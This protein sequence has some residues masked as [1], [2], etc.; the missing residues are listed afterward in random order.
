MGGEHDFSGAVALVTGAARGQ[1]A[2][3][4][5]AF[6]AAGARVVVADVREEQ[7]GVLAAELGDSAVF[8]HLDVS[9]EDAWRRAIELTRATFGRLDVLVNNAGVFR[10]RALEREDPEEFVRVLSIN[11]V[12][13]FLGTRAVVGLMRDTGGGSIVN[14]GSIAGLQPARGT[15]A[16]ATS[17]WG[18]RGLT[19]VS[20]L[21]LARSSIRVNLVV[22]GPI[23]TDML[24]RPPEEVAAGVPLGRVGDPED[25]ARAVLYLASGQASFVTGSEL[26]VDGGRLLE[27]RQTG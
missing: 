27:G 17:K 22:P 16:Y 18:L 25:V 12:G 19:R 24:P 8:A 4:A 20:A 26:V 13:A 9:D 15:A 11:L 7:G 23:A 1:G 2:A 10:T 3:E 6:A 5:R 14:V 21:E